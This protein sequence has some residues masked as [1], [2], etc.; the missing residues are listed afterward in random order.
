MV[1]QEDFAVEQYMD[2]YEKYVKY[3]MG[4]TCCYSLSI[5]E[6]NELA[7]GDANDVS[8]LSQDLLLT[9]LT[10]GHITGSPELK[11]AITNLYQGTGLTSDGIVV[12]NGAIGANFL[13]FYGIVDKGDHVVVVD[14]TYQQLSSV[15]KMFGGNVDLFE[16]KYEDQYQ[17]DLAKL[18]KLVTPNTKLVVI[19]NPNNPTGV[20]WGDDILSQ[21]V[22]I[23]SKNDTYLLCDEVYR[24]LYHSVDHSP[25]SILSFGYEKAIST[26]SISKAFSLAG[27]RLGWIATNDSHL[28]REFLSKR[29]YNTISI[30]IIDDKL[31]TYAL[32]HYEKILE[33]NY[34]LCQENLE[35]IDKYINESKGLLE[36]IR[37]Q[38]GSTCFIKVNKK[39]IDTYKLA[40]DLAEKEGVLLVPGEVFNH[41]GYLRVGFG[42]SK[43]DLEV[44]FPILQKY[45]EQ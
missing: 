26:S 38:G 30:S 24:P 40:C 16:L 9:R 17:P 11:N 23:C 28:V 31:A 18:D 2:K 44:G 43:E 32:N 5:D 13:S 14:P 35:V 25:S 41:R 42:N 19:N 7:G 8:S 39:D 37:P 21:I 36:W 29:D 27:L 20:V 34:K 45:L 22:D 1:K 12:T 10:Y 3:N 33:K 15:P 6:I 4:E